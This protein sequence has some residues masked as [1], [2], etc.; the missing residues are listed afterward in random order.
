MNRLG[1]HVLLYH[2]IRVIRST[3]E[4]SPCMAAVGIASNWSNN[5]CT[6]DIFSCFHSCLS[7]LDEFVDATTSPLLNSKHLK[8]NK[9]S[10]FQT[11]FLY[12]F[13]IFQ[14]FQNYKTLLSSLTLFTHL[15]FPINKWSCWQTD[16]NNGNTF[17]ICAL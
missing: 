16:F 1:A 4:I 11:L 2:F 17:S 13:P 5:V 9:L 14:K 10:I 6:S 15:L 8:I 3:C 7:S 12:F